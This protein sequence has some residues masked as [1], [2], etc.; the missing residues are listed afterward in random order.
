MGGAGV[1]LITILSGGQDEAFHRVVHLEEGIKLGIH[2][3]GIVDDAVAVRIVE[4]IRL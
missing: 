1:F 2:V 4:Q 3:A